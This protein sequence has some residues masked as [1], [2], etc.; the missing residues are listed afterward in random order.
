M[1]ARLGQ[2]PELRAQRRPLPLVPLPAPAAARTRCRDVSGGWRRPSARRA[3]APPG[4]RRR[5]RAEAA[6]ERALTSRAGSAPPLAAGEELGLARGFRCV[7]GAGR[8][9][10]VGL[11]RAGALCLPLPS[12]R[13]FPEAD[14][15]WVAG[16]V[17]QGLQG[18]RLSTAAG[19]PPRS[20]RSCGGPGR[21]PGLP[22]PH[23][24]GS[25]PPP[26]S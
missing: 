1:R 4:G 18:A 20:P 7:P 12:S 23:P 6:L 3:A 5:R 14:K 9:S 13:C 2:R 15:G 19:L 10:S 21:L 8:A 16:S 25:L 22:A 17:E 11:E 26:W 24:A